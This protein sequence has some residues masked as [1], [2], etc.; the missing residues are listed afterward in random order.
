M[1]TTAPE[2]VLAVTPEAIQQ[3]R[4][5][6]EAQHAGESKPLRVYVEAGGCSGL[7]YGML[8]DAQRE[9]DAV[10]TSEGVSVVVDA[11]S[12]GYLRGSILDFSESLTGGGFKVRNPNARQ[13][14]GCGQSFEA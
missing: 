3:L 4:R 2:S 14:C 10:F 5:L 13:S 6:L 7:K 12:A 1:T 11:Q 8:F 9:G